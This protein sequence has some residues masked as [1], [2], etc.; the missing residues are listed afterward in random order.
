MNNYLS[1]HYYKIMKLVPDSEGKNT[2]L[3]AQYHRDRVK[4]WWLSEEL[5]IN[6]W[7]RPA[8]QKL[9][10]REINEMIENAFNTA[11]ISVNLNV[12]KY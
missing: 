11:D 7:A 6:D 4:D 12:W 8:L 1:E 5:F 10:D 9:I 3:R 2:A